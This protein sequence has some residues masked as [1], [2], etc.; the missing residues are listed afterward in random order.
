[1]PIKTKDKGARAEREAKHLLESEGYFCTKSGGS[2]GVY[3]LVAIN[4]KSIR[5]IQV[6]AT[7]NKF[8][9]NG[10][11]RETKLMEE[12]WNLLPKCASQEIWVRERGKWTLY[13]FDTKDKEW[14]V[15]Y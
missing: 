2:L 8:Y 5:L 6:K 7:S 15:M 9:W 10:V 14:G 13:V 11:K 3:D 4:K 12:S 1:M